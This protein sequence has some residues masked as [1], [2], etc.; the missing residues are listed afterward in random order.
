MN[1]QPRRWND[2]FVLDFVG[3]LHQARGDRFVSQE[4]TGGG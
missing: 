1:M 4:A 3:D 2:G